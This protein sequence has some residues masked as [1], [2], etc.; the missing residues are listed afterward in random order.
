MKD[1]IQVMG[2]VLKVSSCGEADRRLVLLTRE[3][4][5]ITVFA[6]GAKRPKLPRI[7]KRPATD[8][9]SWSWLTITAGK[10]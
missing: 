9:I 8:R 4:G 7:W 3:R 6:R 2:M 1:A 10:T 5:K